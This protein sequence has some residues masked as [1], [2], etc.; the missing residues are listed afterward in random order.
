ME[1]AQQSQHSA[2][3]IERHVDLFGK[4]V[5]RD[6][7]ESDQ[8]HDSDGNQAHFMITEIRLGSFSDSRG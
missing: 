8:E 5:T 2:P 4:I 1:R 3:E 7:V 6:Y